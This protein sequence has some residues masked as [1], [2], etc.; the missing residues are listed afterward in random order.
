MERIHRY[1]ATIN[2]IYHGLSFLSDLSVGNYNFPFLCEFVFTFFALFN[3]CVAIYTPLYIC[4]STFTDE[5]RQSLVSFRE[6]IS[7]TAT[8]DMSNILH[9]YTF[10][11]RFIIFLFSFLLYAAIILYYKTMYLGQF[12]QIVMFIGATVLGP[13]FAWWTLVDFLDCLFIY[14]NTNSIYALVNSIF[15]AFS[16]PAY[17][18]YAIK[19]TVDIRIK[20]HTVASLNSPMTVGWVSLIY[21]LAIFQEVMVHSNTAQYLCYFGLLFDT[22]VAT[23]MTFSSCI[24]RHFSNLYIHILTNIC[25]SVCS[26]SSFI[27][28]IFFAIKPKSMTLEIIVHVVFDIIAA[29]ISTSYIL[30]RRAKAKER[31]RNYD[32]IDPME[33]SLSEFIYCISESNSEKDQKRFPI[34]ILD[35]VSEAYHNQLES[36]IL[37]L[38]F[39]VIKNEHYNIILKKAQELIKF[40]S[41]SFLN[42]MRL[43]GIASIAS[44]E[45]LYIDGFYFLNM[46]KVNQLLIPLYQDIHIFWKS[47]LA[48]DIASVRTTMIHFA[49]NSKRFKFF[50]HTSP[51]LNE[52]YEKTVSFNIADYEPDDV[53]SEDMIQRAK[54]V[55]L[56]HPKLIEKLISFH[57]WFLIISLVFCFAQS[58][59]DLGFS[60]ESV[61]LP[62]TI[63]EL[64]SAQQ[65]LINIIT[66][67]NEYMYNQSLNITRILIPVNCSK[68]DLFQYIYTQVNDLESNVIF[69]EY[70]NEDNLSKYINTMINAFDYNVTYNEPNSTYAKISKDLGTQSIYFTEALGVITQDIRDQTSTADNHQLNVFFITSIVGAVFFVI[71]EICEYLI[72]K[73]GTEGINQI[74]WQPA[75]LEKPLILYMVNRYQQLKESMGTQ[76]EEDQNQFLRRIDNST[77]FFI[78]LLVIPVSILSSC[79]SYFVTQNEA[80]LMYRSTYYTPISPHLFSALNLIAAVLADPTDIASYSYLNVS[81]SYMLE[82]ASIMAGEKFSFNYEPNSF[83]TNESDMLNYTY[84]FPHVAISIGTEFLRTINVNV[85]GYMQNYLTSLA[86]K[87]QSMVASMP[88]T[89]L[90]ISASSLRAAIEV[91]HRIEVFNTEISS[92]VEEKWQ[93]DS[94]QKILYFAVFIIIDIFFCSFL[95]ETVDTIGN[96]IKTTLRMLAYVPGS[97]F[98][99]PDGYYDLQP[100]PLSHTEQLLECIPSGIIFYTNDNIITRTNYEAQ[101]IYGHDL[102]G[103]KISAVK[104]DVTEE[105]GTK[106]FYRIRKY[107]ASQ[108]PCSFFDPKNDYPF[109]IITDITSLL[110]IKEKVKIMSNDL[111]RDFSIPSVL[112]I[113]TVYPMKQS[114]LVEIL[115]DPSTSDNDFNDF[116]E[117]IKE[118]SESSSSLFYL[119][120]VR[121]SCFA[122]FYAIEEKQRKLQYSEAIKFSIA[123]I[124]LFTKYHIKATIGASVI[125]LIHAVIPNRNIPKINFKSETMWKSA[126][127]ASYGKTGQIVMENRLLKFINENLLVILKTDTM[128]YYQ[129]EIR[130]DIAIPSAEANS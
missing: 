107:S 41:V 103:Q 45:N 25:T 40:N 115:I 12:W 100:P 53:I 33:V 31:L 26:T 123:V 120:T 67:Y 60:F 125:N 105:D 116:A 27:G 90:L 122:I 74:C 89:P 104:S 130:F 106:K 99:A 5:E 77:I 1:L 56:F 21:V 13:L 49:S 95:Y 34:E 3:T 81:T 96:G 71:L 82:I 113:N 117:A 55:R 16:I 18:L 118:L 124:Q 85:R 92:V 65:N 23:Y 64:I 11:I 72:L 70:L 86:L 9:Q 78:S 42:I 88:E 128:K 10:Y 98:F 50:F 44:G 30:Y 66:A 126:A 57:N 29:I 109:V 37:F 54:T 61:N 15:A 24:Y 102:L 111:K 83:M 76:R 17:I 20:P 4:S 2:P 63:Q 39:K 79:V 7:P 121:W 19:A 47:A 8:S 68:D 119:D 28:L 110:E 51:D 87:V 127:L 114:V 59:L 69:Q 36:I 22:A 75:I 58:T 80:D 108:F 101:E 32:I 43:K 91:A 97:P 93:L 52:L 35:K 129:E 112:Q 14:L 38:A 84:N 62:N 46:K 73:K 48:G 6:I 94:L